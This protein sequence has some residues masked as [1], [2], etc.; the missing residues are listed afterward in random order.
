M[1]A[2][3]LPQRLVI[4][5][6]F[7][8]MNYS[9]QLIYKSRV[10][11]KDKITMIKS[12]QDFIVELKNNGEDSSIS[13]DANLKQWV[14]STL[15]MAFTRS[16]KQR[17]NSKIHSL[18]IQRLTNTEKTKSLTFWKKYTYMRIKRAV[19][20]SVS[21]PHETGKMGKPQILFANG[22]N[23]VKAF[24]SSGIA[25]MKRLMEGEGMAMSRS[26]AAQNK[27]TLDASPQSFLTLCPLVTWTPKISKY[28]RQNVC[29]ANLRFRHRAVRKH[30]L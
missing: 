8:Q 15:L 4:L 9:D 14:I 6:S 7:G 24:G 20:L 21:R 30:S 29:S 26:T 16:Q 28:L 25:G 12:H 18:W 19:Q 11:I 5:K 17:K 2:H 1:K 22:I 10:A 27:N 3:D 23:L 13:K